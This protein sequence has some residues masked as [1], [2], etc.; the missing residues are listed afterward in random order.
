MV[1]ADPSD[2]GHGKNEKVMWNTKVNEEDIKK[3]KEKGTEKKR[4]GRE[5]ERE[6]QG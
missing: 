2:L 3:E 5:E 6:G 1:M 4:K